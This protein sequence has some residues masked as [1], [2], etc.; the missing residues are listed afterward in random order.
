VKAVD[1]FEALTSES[2]VESLELANHDH[3]IERRLS[4]SDR[5]LVR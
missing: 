4:A 2:T 1:L 5:P 3:T